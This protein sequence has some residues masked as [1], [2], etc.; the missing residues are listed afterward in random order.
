[1]D[2]SGRRS[3]TPQ[4]ALAPVQEDCNVSSLIAEFWQIVNV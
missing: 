1:M 4:Q 3:I 2:K